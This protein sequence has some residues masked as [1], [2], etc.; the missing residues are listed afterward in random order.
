M[1]TRLT[2]TSGINEVSQL[3]SRIA[4]LKA[5]MVPGGVI[6]QADIATLCALWNDWI[7]HTHLV[8]DLQNSLV[9]PVKS[10]T[11]YTTRPAWTGAVV[12]AV[13]APSSG[14]L[15]RYNTISELVRS[16]SSGLTHY[17]GWEDSTS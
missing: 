6:K 10:Q 9:S 3:K 13:G 15:I 17:H 1:T 11:V 7:L 12:L 5:S 2:A 14:S 8:E 4:A 16:A